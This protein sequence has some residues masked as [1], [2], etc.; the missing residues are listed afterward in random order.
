MVAAGIRSAI[1]EGDVDRALKYAQAFYPKVLPSNEAVHFKLRCR[2]FI[3]MVRRVAEL[4]MSGSP[5]SRNNGTVLAATVQSMDLDQGRDAGTRQPTTL[6]DLEQ[7]IISYGK[8]LQAEYSNDTRGDFTSGLQ[9]IWS[10]L[11]YNNPLKEPQVKHM[12]D[13]QGR[14]VVAEELNS[15][16]LCKCRKSPG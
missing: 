7:E 15:A 3:E 10:L 9:E 4:K 13:Q 5:S 14:V 8:S 11:A 12:L 16:I 2:K 6:S 1:L